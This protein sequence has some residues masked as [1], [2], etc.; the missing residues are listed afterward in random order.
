MY[1]PLVPTLVLVALYAGFLL[2]HHRWPARPL[3][4][5]EID[6]ALRLHTDET[7]SAQDRARLRDFML[8]DD[9]KP[10]YMVNL[11]ALRERALYP[12]GRFPEATSGR[13]AHALYGRMVLR[14]LLKRG[15]YPVFVSRKIAT[16]IM[17]GPGTDRFDE[18]AII[19]YRSRRDMLAMIGDPVYVAGVVHKWAALESTLIIATRRLLLVDLGFAVPMLL[20]LIAFGMRRFG[21]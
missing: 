13:H 2:W 11:M 20:L 8:A 17:A 21:G 5:P 19:R 4:A 12:Q 1:P 6:A 18:V 7:T 9:G 10:Y 3:T 15:S 16:F 14:Q